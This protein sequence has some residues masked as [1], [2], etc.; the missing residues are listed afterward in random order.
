[1]GRVRRPSSGEEQ[2]VAFWNS[3][4]DNGGDREASI[5]ALTQILGPEQA[6]LRASMAQRLASEKS[7]SAAHTLAKAAIFDASVE[8]RTEA[9]KALKNY[10]PEQYSNV[11]LAGL[12][13]PMPVVA[14]RAAVAMIELKRNDMFGEIVGFLAEAPPGDPVVGE[15]GEC[16]VREV[17]RINHH[18]NCLMCHAP[19]ATGSTQEVPG[20]IPTP[21]MPFP[22]TSQEYYG[23]VAS[24]GEPAVRADTTYLRQDFSV[25][26]PVAD[27]AP[28]PEMQRFD[29]LVRNRVVA[30]KELTA[31]QQKVAERAAGFVSENHQAAIRVLRELSGQNAA[32]TAE[33]WRQA[34]GL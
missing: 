3:Y 21:G 32:P 31:L 8:V 10:A 23:D 18:R 14:S 20:L 9:I 12:R 27:A 22:S 7:Q 28:W 30:G 11:L 26:L 16:T 33:G 29:F 1:L 25:M 19:T 2:H 34:L 4:V 15:Q 24:R 13:Y 5:A 6:K 17:V